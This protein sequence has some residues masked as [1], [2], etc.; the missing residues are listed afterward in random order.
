MTLS[1]IQPW[2]RKRESLDE[3]SSDDVTFLQKPGSEPDKVLQF[4]VN[5]ATIHYLQAV[6]YYLRQVSRH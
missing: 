3:A 2:L 5:I 1:N 6:A 4:T